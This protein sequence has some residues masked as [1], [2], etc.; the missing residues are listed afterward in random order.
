LA[1]EVRNSDPFT[2]G[3]APSDAERGWFVGQFV[4]PE[5][6]LRRRDDVEIKWGIHPAGEGREKGWSASRVATTITVLLQGSFRMRLAVDGGVRDFHLREPGDYLVFG[7][8][9][10]HTWEAPEGCIM[11][12]V[13]TP[14]LPDDEVPCDPPD[15]PPGRGRE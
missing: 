1:K 15:R 2:F 6:G 11:L 10:P 9:L 13:R 4:A 12:T 5:G 8:G 14:S 3:H 7:P